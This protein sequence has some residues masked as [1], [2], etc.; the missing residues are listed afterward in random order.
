MSHSEPQ[1]MD[2]IERALK[3]IEEEGQGTGKFVGR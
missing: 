2:I 1:W 3:E